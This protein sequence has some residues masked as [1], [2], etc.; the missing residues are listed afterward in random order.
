MLLLTTSWSYAVNFITTTT[1]GN[2][3]SASTYTLGTGTPGVNDRIYVRTGATLTVNVDYTVSE[4]RVGVSTSAG[5]LVVNSGKTLTLTNS[6]TT[7]STAASAIRTYGTNTTITNNGTIRF[8][9]SS[10]SNYMRFNEF[11]VGGDIE[12]GGEIDIV[13]GTLVLHNVDLTLI[14]KLK[15]DGGIIDTR[16]GETNGATL[17]LKN[18]HDAGDNG[19]VSGLSGNGNIVDDYTIIRTFRPGNIWTNAAYGALSQPFDITHGDIDDDFTTSGYPASDNPTFYPQYPSITFYDQ[20][21]VNCTSCTPAR[22]NTQDAGWV[23]APTDA[24]S[25]DRGRGWF[26]YESDSLATGGKIDWEIKGNAS[27]TGDFSTTLKWNS[28]ATAGAQGWNLIGNPYPGTLDLQEVYDSYPSTWS[29]ENALWNYNP[30]TNAYTG[31][32]PVLA[33]KFGNTAFTT[34]QA[35]YISV[36]EAIWV[37]QRTGATST[38]SIPREAVYESLNPI[39]NARQSVT[40]GGVDDFVF[41]AEYRDMDIVHFVSDEAHHSFEYDKYNYADGDVEV[42]FDNSLIAFG[43]DA[44]SSEFDLWQVKTSEMEAGYWFPDDDGSRPYNQNGGVAMDTFFIWI[45]TTGEYANP[46]D[47]ILTNKHLS[48][49]GSSQEIFY[50]FLNQDGDWEQVEDG[51]TTLGEGAWG[52]WHTSGTNSEWIAATALRWGYSDAGPI[53]RMA[54]T[55]IT[56]V[57]GENSINIFP[58]PVSDQLTIEIDNVT[59]ERLNADITDIS[60]RV[61]ETIRLRGSKVQLNTSNYDSGVYILNVRGETTSI[62]KRIVVQ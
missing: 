10:A 30:A 52:Y 44:F 14:G 45:D 54:P 38:F 43:M 61:I 11:T 36:C 50:E 48:S 8:N 21:S 51:G 62:V 2:I 25:I 15:L 34:Q 3:N 35:R 20:D 23:I 37:E 31:W 18:T 41:R 5:T 17:T 4:I 28:G 27:Y 57:E 12:I 56:E 46:A 9:P 29:I 33:V 39:H 24:Y 26:I 58:N 42:A 49:Y 59:G 19:R 32:N 13:K 7:L 6:S 16:D 55:G 40:A 47:L 60:G 53:A 1:G 22:P